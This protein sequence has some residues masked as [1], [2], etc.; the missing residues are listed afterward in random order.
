[1]RPPFPCSG[2]L[3][4]SRTTWSPRD[5]I[6]S[7]GWKASL[8]SIWRNS[9][10]LGSMVPWRGP[11]REEKDKK[12]SSRRLRKAELCLRSRPN[13]EKGK[14][15]GTSVQRGGV[16]TCYMQ[17]MVY[18]SISQDSLSCKCQKPCQ[19]SISEG[20]NSPARITEENK[21]IQNHTLLHQHLWM[22]SLHVLPALFFFS[23]ALFL[24]PPF[25][26]SLS[27]S[28]FYLPVSTFHVVSKMAS[29]CSPRLMLSAYQPHGRLVCP[30]AVPAKVLGHVTMA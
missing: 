17:I 13:P 23:L 5:C 19:I 9:T 4:G 15:P 16:L 24:F 21:K 2:L 1:M 14:V 29:C 26:L 22:D 28:H 30:P 27:F 18:Q 25:S 10:I 20:E 11:W 8:C 6:Y 12:V 3:T 7:G